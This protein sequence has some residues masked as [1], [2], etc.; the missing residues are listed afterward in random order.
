[1]PN[2][3]PKGYW[4]PQIDVNDPEGYKAYMAATPPAH[5]KY[6]GVALAR[7]GR[8]EVVEGHVRSRCVLREFPDY[9]AA[10]ACYRSEEYQRARPLR[11]AYATSDFVI[12]EG[13]DGVQPPLSATPPATAAAKGYW[14]AHA[15]VTNPE[16]YKAY[17]AADMAPFGKFGGRFLVRGG[18]RDVPEGR[19]RGRTVV[20]EFPSYDA[21]LACYRSPDYQAA[22]KLR[23]GNADFDLIVVEGYGGPKF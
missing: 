22:K 4:I 19:V 3:V 10:L 15:D 9:A 5:E 6:C 13:Y 1:M 12:V 7:G 16:G 17:M 21:A 14:I 8:S 11:Q 20:L 23:D 18:A 2:A